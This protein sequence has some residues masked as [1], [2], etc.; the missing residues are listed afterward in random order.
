MVNAMSG[1]SALHSRA[2]A[3]RI[4]VKPKWCLKMSARKWGSC[5]KK[6]ATNCTGRPPPPSCPSS[7]RSCVILGRCQSALPRNHHR[8]ARTQG[9]RLQEPPKNNADTTTVESSSM[10]V[11]PV[12]FRRLV[13]TDYSCWSQSSFMRSPHSAGTRGSTNTPTA[14]A[15][16]T[17]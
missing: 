4:S 7:C 9:L 3:T 11:M 13:T 2:S 5:T 17:A 15:R 14:A 12:T 1:N 8:H 10:R 16:W 6:T